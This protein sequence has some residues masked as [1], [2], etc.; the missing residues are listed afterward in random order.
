MPNGARRRAGS[1]WRILLFSYNRTKK[2]KNIKFNHCRQ[3][4][5]LKIRGY[6]NA[7]TL[8]GKAFCRQ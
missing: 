7:V 4:E 1:V 3:T 6:K 2:N 8:A 5:K